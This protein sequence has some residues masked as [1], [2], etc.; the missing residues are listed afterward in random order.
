MDYHIAPAEL[1]I[2][3]DSTNVILTNKIHANHCMAVMDSVSNCKYLFYDRSLVARW[4]PE[5]GELYYI[6]NFPIKVRKD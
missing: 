1:G 6:G 5:G 3:E 2:L 4:S